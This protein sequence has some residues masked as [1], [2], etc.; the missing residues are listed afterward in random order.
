MI[1]CLW[2][3]CKASLPLPFWK[4]KKKKKEAGPAPDSRPPAA[5]V[6]A[7]GTGADGKAIVSR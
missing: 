1:T 7:T 4:K 6:R 2:H 5:S 3:L